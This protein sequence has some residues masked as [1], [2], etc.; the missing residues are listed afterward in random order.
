LLLAAPAH[1]TGDP[2]RLAD[3]IELSARIAIDS[4]QAIFLV[5]VA[6]LLPLAV[7]AWRYRSL[8]T[9]AEPADAAALLAMLV[10]TPVSLAL[11][12]SPD[13]VLAHGAAWCL[14]LAAWTAAGSG[15][16]RPKASYR[17]A[18]VCVAPSS[19]PRRWF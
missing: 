19:R 13:K 5:F 11:N 18:P 7:I 10:A 12:D 9:G 6:G 4:P 3:R 17:L 1:L 8:R 2:G 15:I 16:R 14:A